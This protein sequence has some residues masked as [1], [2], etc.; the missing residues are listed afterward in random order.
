MFEGESIRGSKGKICG[1]VYIN[2]QASKACRQSVTWDEQTH[3]GGR[4]GQLSTSA[5]ACPAGGFSFT[6]L[7]L[8]V[9]QIKRELLIFVS[10]FE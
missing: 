7:L 10:Q 1:V 2:S 4:S 5:K 8:E 6:V 3:M 9:N